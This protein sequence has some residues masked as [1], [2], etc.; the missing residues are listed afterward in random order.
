MTQHNFQ[1]RFGNDLNRL[2]D[3]LTETGRTVWLAG[4][5]AVAQVEQ[6]GRGFFEDLVE[7]GRKVEKRQF[8]AIDR[9]L[10]E[11]SKR[12]KDF[13]DKVQD[14]VEGGMKDTLHRLGLATGDDLKVLAG[15]LD[16]LSQKV[17][18]VAAER[19]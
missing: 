14:R 3:E 19:R 11:T 4:L 7:K 2:R 10:S 5:G 15:R 1:E 8:K 12:V 16:N 6:E 18:S 9:T 17:D 13:G